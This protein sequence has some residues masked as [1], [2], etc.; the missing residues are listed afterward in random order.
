MH[1]HFNRT[2]NIHSQ[3]CIYTCIYIYIY[4]YIYQHKVLLEPSSLG[5]KACTREPLGQT[6]VQVQINNVNKE[7]NT[8]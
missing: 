6:H 1:E 5:L 7:M 2:L 4:I 8:S 3:N